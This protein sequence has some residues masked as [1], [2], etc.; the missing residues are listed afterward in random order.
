M[1]KGIQVTGTNGRL[2][3][4]F[5]RL[6]SNVKRENVKRDRRGGSGQ[7]SQK[8]FDE[9]AICGLEPQLEPQ[10]HLNK[11]PGRAETLDRVFVGGFTSRVTPVPIPNTVVKPAGPM[12]LLQRESRLLPALN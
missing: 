8:E 12:I 3:D 6:P 11:Q 2:L 7:N 10:H 4:H 5:Y 1:L 9:I